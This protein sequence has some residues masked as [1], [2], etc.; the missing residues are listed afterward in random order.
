[1]LLLFKQGTKTKAWWRMWID[2]WLIDDR[3]TCGSPA[4]FCGWFIM[5]VCGQP[6]LFELA[7]YFSSFLS[8]SFHFIATLVP[9]VSDYSHRVDRNSSKVFHWIC[10]FSISAQNYCSVIWKPFCEDAVLVNLMRIFAKYS[11]PFYSFAFHSF[12][13]VTAIFLC[14]YGL[15]LQTVYTFVFQ[16]MDFDTH[17]WIFVRQTFMG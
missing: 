10:D 3:Q 6:N 17:N 13:F 12:K 4:A 11:F 15:S 8:N 14:F 5:F 9:S 1:M 7:V 2:W 16:K